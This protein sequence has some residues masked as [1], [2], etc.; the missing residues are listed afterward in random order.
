[1]EESEEDS[2]AGADVLGGWEGMFEDRELTAED[3]S[4]D[5][6]AEAARANKARKAEIKLQW[7][8][9]A[10][11]LSSALRTITEGLCSVCVWCWPVLAS[12][13]IVSVSE[14]SPRARE[15]D[16]LGTEH[17]AAVCVQSPGAS[18]CCVCPAD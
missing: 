6:F 1:M 15:H 16:W 18:C 4:S 5:P 7:T 13:C 3:I 14:K 2:A 10:H 8:Q 12:L 17:H 9:G 11:A